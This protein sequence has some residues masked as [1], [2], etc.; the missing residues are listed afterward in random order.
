MLWLKSWKMS[1]LIILKLWLLKAL[2]SL[3]LSMILM[4]IVRIMLN[5]M[6][7]IVVI[8]MII[9]GLWLE[10]V[11]GGR[12]DMLGLK[13]KGFSQIFLFFSSFKQNKTKTKKRFRI[14]SFAML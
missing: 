13:V 5:F 14:Y 12:R 7:L 10:K 4:L 1:C 2:M 3:V 6:G 9:R 8:I 11:R